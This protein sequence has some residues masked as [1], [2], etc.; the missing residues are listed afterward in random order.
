MNLH[1]IPY[2]I[3]LILSGGT[4]LILA[5]YL[6]KNDQSLK[7]KIFIFL[8]FF[9]SFWSLAYALQIFSDQYSWI[10]FWAKIKYFGIVL[11]PITWLLFSLLCV[12]KK[13]RVNKK[14]IILISIIPCIDL[15]FL[16][17]NELHYLF[18]SDMGLVNIENINFLYAPEGI[19]FWLNVIYSYT[20][21]V[22][23]SAL[24][25]GILKKSKH[26]YLKQAIALLIGVLTPLIGSVIYV[27][28]LIPLPIDYDITPMLFLVAG[29][30]FTFAFFRFQFLK[31]MPIVREQFFENVNDAVFIIGY[32]DKIV[33]LNKKAQQFAKENSFYSQISDIVGKGVDEIFSDMKNYKEIFSN[34]NSYNGENLLTNG[35]NPKYYDV[36]IISLY[37]KGNIYGGKMIILRDITERKNSE[38]KLKE[39]IDELERWKKV[40][41]DRELKMVELKSEIK[42]LEAKLPGENR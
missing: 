26:L 27:T 14:N 40:T 21:I 42:E 32:Q 10:V 20:L 37:D 19:F 7:A 3:P 16:F 41:V 34:N 15:V 9:L 13:E 25:I 17:T 29:M 38:N 31:I 4:L 18:W 12:G 22:V 36:Q 28:G 24:I 6:Y 1:A 35:E 5:T 33:D 39:K 23:G 2:I 30:C 11:F 8:L